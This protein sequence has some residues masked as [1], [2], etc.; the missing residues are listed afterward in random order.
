MIE[1]CA[2][3]GDSATPMTFKASAL[4]T[5]FENC[6]SNRI[7]RLSQ[8]AQPEPYLFNCWSHAA[9]PPYN[10]SWSWLE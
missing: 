10:I 2:S 4:D 5:G 9:S 1:M 6:Q 8:I 7:R 3:H